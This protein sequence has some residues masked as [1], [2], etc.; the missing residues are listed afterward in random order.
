[1]NCHSESQ[2]MKFI[3]ILLANRRTSP[4][5]YPRELVKPT[6]WDDNGSSGNFLALPQSTSIRKHKINQIS[7]ICKKWTQLKGTRSQHASTYSTTKIKF[8]INKFKLHYHDYHDNNH[9]NNKS[10]EFDVLEQFFQSI[11]LLYWRPIFFS[12]FKV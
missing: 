6:T 7:K 11:I 10:T 3:V 4:C 2:N 12:T 9:H 5:F 8:K 1:M